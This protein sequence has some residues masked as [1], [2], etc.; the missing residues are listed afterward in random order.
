MADRTTRSRPRCCP[1]CARSRRQGCRRQHLPRGRHAHRPRRQADRWQRAT[2]VRRQLDHG[3]QHLAVPPPQGHAAARAD[4]CRRSTRA[5]PRRTGWRLAQSLPIVFL[6][7]VEEH[8]TITG[9]A[10]YG[11]SDNLAGATIALFTESTANRVLEAQNKY[12]S[13]LVSA[14]SGV[15]DVVLRERLAAAL[16]SYAVAETGQQAAAAAEQSTESTISTFIGTPLLVFAFISLFVGQLSHHQHVQHPGGAAHARAGA[17]ARAR[18]H[19]G[20]GDDV[21]ACRGGGDR[22][23]GVDP[24]FLCWHPDRASSALGLR[25]G[26][27]RAA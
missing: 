7:G 5:P 13:I 15:T 17:V 10:G 27:P 2:D 8:F 23:G 19:S 4:R 21:G 3:R 26:R 20:P 6:G 9:V 11:T 24:R 25:L 18:C 12:D 16:P 14:Q 22:G 1:L